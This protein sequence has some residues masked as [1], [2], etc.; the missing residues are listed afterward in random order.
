[1]KIVKFISIFVLLIGFTFALV[2]CAKEE[3]NEQTEFNK[4]DNPEFILKTL[5]KHGIYPNKGKINLQLR[6]V[7][8][9]SCDPGDSCSLILEITDT[10]QISG[11]CDS[12]YVYYKLYN[13]NGKFII[14]NFAAYPMWPECA[15]IWDYWWDLADL[16]K[17]T[18]M[19]ISMDSFEYAAS[20]IYERELMGA[21]VE[22]YNILCKN[23]EFVSSTLIRQICYR[24][25]LEK[26][27][28][29]SP[30]PWPTNLK[31][32]VKK[33]K[34]GDKCCE[35]MR[36]FCLNQDGS[37]NVSDPI[38]NVIGTDVCDAVPNDGCNGWWLGPCEHECSAPY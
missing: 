19:E 36:K 24:Y 27:I 32:K 26:A 25:C 3:F 35:R 11:T 5:A 23:G 37:L 6:D 1:M 38:W 12:V 18:Q 14:S 30:W 31:W 2:Q 8:N 21:I 22:G 15:S 17:Y 16:G 9:V 20:L 4:R 13:C 28:K 33:I 29:K 10:M 7:L 34:C